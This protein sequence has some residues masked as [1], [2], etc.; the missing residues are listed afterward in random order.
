VRGALWGLAAAE[1]A[2]FGVGLVWA[3][4]RD[5]PLPLGFSPRLLLLALVAA[6]VLAGL[7]LSLY[8]R[9]RR[10]WRSAR[11]IVFLEEEVFP[12]FR[13]A[14]TVELSLL[15]ALAGL[16][17]EVFFR[18]V[19]QSETGLVPASLLFGLAH[20]PTPPLAG[21]AAWAAAMGLALGGLYLWSGSL[22][23][24]ILVHAAYDLAALVYLRRL[25]AAEELRPN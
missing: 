15:S 1:A 16:G 21:L 25:K 20:G 9:L 8:H 22:A 10:R 2:L 3:W 6:L 23:V 7:N 14:S 18:G 24:A 17:E 4:L 12:I 19:L 13:G 11:V 5:I